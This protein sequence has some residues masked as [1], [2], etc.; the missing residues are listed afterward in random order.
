MRER[1]LRGKARDDSDV[2]VGG[3]VADAAF[4]R[5]RHFRDWLAD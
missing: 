3:R 4:W 5:L 1:R 2:E